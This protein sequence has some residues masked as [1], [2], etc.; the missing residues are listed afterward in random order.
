MKDNVNTGPPRDSQ[1]TARLIKGASK[2]KPSK[3]P[4]KEVEDEKKD[5]TQIGSD[6][7]EVGSTVDLDI[8]TDES[9]KTTNDTKDQ[10]GLF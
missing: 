8:N 4:K 9:S 1:K 2:P 7:F 10:L 6:T 3:K 5:S